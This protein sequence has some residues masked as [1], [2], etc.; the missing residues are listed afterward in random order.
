[1]RTSVS[2]IPTMSPPSCNVETQK[3]SDFDLKAK[4]AEIDS[5]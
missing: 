5:G 4:K 3:P 2:R 1:M